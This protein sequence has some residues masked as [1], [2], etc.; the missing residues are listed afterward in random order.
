VAR[1]ECG[2]QLACRAMM[3]FARRVMTAAEL[4]QSALSGADMPAG[5]TPARHA[6]WLARAGRWHEAHEQ[7]QNISGAAGSWIHAHL[8]RQE[9][10]HGN[11]AYWYARAGRP[12]PPRD[13]SIVA[14][15]LELA[16]EL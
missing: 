9:G 14:E 8:H 4:E 15:W 5:L 11:A 3:G 6:L 1:Q 2:Y 7:C 12:V 16:A 10:D 13:L